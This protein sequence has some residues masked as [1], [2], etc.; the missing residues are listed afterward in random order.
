MLSPKHPDEESAD[1][2]VARLEVYYSD[3][4]TAIH[5]GD[6]FVAESKEKLRRTREAARLL[7]EA[8]PEC[9]GVE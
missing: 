4:A 1:D 3:A 9:H 2:F 8:K 7:K 6:R 5:R